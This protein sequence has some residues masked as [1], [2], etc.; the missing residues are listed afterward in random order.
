M[1]GGTTDD[2]EQKL[3][4]LA[5]L[6]GRHPNI[7]MPEVY[8]KACKKWRGAFSDAQKRTAGDA[9]EAF[10]AGDQARAIEI[11]AALPPAPRFM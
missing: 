9:L 11:A 6:T 3:H 7:A 1:A 2:A 8:I 4:A 10:H 5:V